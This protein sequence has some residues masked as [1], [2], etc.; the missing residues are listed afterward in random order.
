MQAPEIFQ[1]PLTSLDL[2]GLP[3]RDSAGFR[4]A[5]IARYAVEYA[6]RGWTAVITVDD[7]FV[8]GVAVPE[9]SVE[10]V[11]YVLGLLQN[12]F[13]EDALPLLEAL[14]GMLDD[15]EIAYNYGVCLSEVS[16]V[17]ECIAPLERCIQLDPNYTNAYVAL[18]LAFAKLSRNDEAVDTL[19]KAIAQQPENVWANRNLAG[20]LARAG[21]LAEALPFFRR[22]VALSPNEPP[23]YM[24]LA[25]CLDELGGEQRKEADMV[26]SE[27]MKRFPDHPVAEAAKRARN[28][29]SNEQLHSPVGG[30]V[31][32]DAVF[33]MQQAMDTFASRSRDEAGRIIM[34]IA[35]LGESGLKINDPT[36]RYSLKTLPGDYSGLQ[37]L[38]MMHV[39][40]RMLDPKA[41]TGSGLDREYELAK[42]V[43][44]N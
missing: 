18:G 6:S 28:R 19:R 20:V 15:P 26:Y 11:R 44:A 34:E 37:L 7:E 16:K 2:T 31:R 14:Y 43:R 12:G 5:V 38:S 3:A 17:A 23:L 29:I 32:M 41:E 22:S 21:K 24:G 8:R 4:D 1:K 36:V 33:Y 39:G 42:S 35:R 13:L 30:S 10:P 25:Q 40:I 27:L 9:Q